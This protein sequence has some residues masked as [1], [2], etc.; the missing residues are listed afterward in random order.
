MPVKSNMLVILV[1]GQK[2]SFSLLLG[3]LSFVAL[4]VMLEI[5][6]FFF[7]LILKSLLGF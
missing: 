2:A 6:F 7:F 5:F 4:R 1:F 3:M